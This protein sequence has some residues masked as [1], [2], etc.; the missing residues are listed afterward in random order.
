MSIKGGLGPL[1]DLKEL[2]YVSLDDMEVHIGNDEELAW[3][4]KN[5]PKIL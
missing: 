4:E 3:V 2:E 1:R 5:W